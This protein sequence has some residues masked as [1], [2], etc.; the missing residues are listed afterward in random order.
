VLAVSL[1]VYYLLL[2]ISITNFISNITR[3]LII[4]LLWTQSH[5]H[6]GLWH[7]YPPKQS[8][9]PQIEIWNTINQWSFCQFSECQA[10]LHK[11][12]AP[13]LKTFWTVCWNINKS[14]QSCIK[15]Q[16]SLHGFNMAQ[17][18]KSLFWPG[19]GKWDGQHIAAILVVLSAI[20]AQHRLCSTSETM[21]FLKCS[22]ISKINLITAT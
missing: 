5:H 19:C 8:S 11:R 18:W 14:I 12:K 10:V 7:S 22:K 2:S 1:S 17:I 16:V 4:E 21:R 6:G 20:L 15:Q 3:A 9:Q 13:L